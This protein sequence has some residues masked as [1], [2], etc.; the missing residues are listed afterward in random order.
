MKTAD[1]H[2]SPYQKLLGLEL[3]SAGDDGVSIRLPADAKLLRIEGSSQLH[4]GV[5]SALVDIAGSYAVE[6]AVGGDA[7]TIDLRIDYLKPAMGEVVATARVLKR[8]RTLCVADVEIR[9]AQQKLVA[10]GR[11]L[12]ANSN[13][14]E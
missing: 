14:S 4:G 2:I 3:V 1:L 5:L 11:G 7:P 10:T 13:R 8:G 6:V 9:D 12:Y